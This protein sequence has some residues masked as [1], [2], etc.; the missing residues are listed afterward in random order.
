MHSKDR[1]S[2]QSSSG[3]AHSRRV[4]LLLAAIAISASLMGAALAPA[5]ASALTSPLQ[6]SFYTPPSNLASLADGTIIRSREVTMSGPQQAVTADAYQLFFRTT[7][8]TGQP[9]A[10]VT[11]VLVPKV[12]AP[13]TRVLA[14]Y[15]P[16]YDSMTLN[17]APS[18]TLQGGNPNGGGTGDL[19]EGLI[20]SELAEGWDVNVPDY[21]GL[22]SE[23]AVAPMLGHASLDS[24]IAAEHFAADGLTAG[25][26]TKV[27]FTGYS[28]GSEAADWAA[29]L[30]PSYAPQLNIIGIAAGGNFPDFDYTL[31]QFDGSLWYGIEIG[32][33]ESFSRAYQQINLKQLLNPAGQAL[34]AQDGSN[35][36]GCSS[37]TLNEPYGNASEFTNF[38]TSEAFAADPTVKQV[39]D[40]MSLRYAPYPNVPEYLYNSVDDDVA[41]IIP[42]DALVK[43]YCAAG[44]QVD[45]DRDATG[46]D[47]ITA[48]PHW[49][50]GALP[51]LIDRYAGDSVPDNCSTYGRSSPPGNTTTTTRSRCRLGAALVHGTAL[52]PARLHMTRAR[53]RHA[54]GRRGV[55][56]GA[57]IQVFCG[58]AGV[59]VGY[60]TPAEMGTIAA[61]RRRGLRGHLVWA[62]TTNSRY[63]LHDVRDG[64]S[65][66][67]PVERR[68]NLTLAAVH[69]R[70][71]WYLTRLAGATGL[72]E[73]R[74]GVVRLIG[75][76]A[77]SLTDR[78]AS[79]RVLLTTIARTARI[80]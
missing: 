60:A 62:V 27:T 65:L 77:R 25:A 3:G 75:I 80:G 74:A 39:L 5:A 20:A 49:W 50:A 61:S 37:S 63:V 10:T 42:V 79:R 40:K 36:A 67:R 22:Q 31:G 7:N 68:A 47:H 58:A 46:G 19:E 57:Y 2:D 30:A 23:W 8:A 34:A 16:A 17:C 4:A 69:G 41:H 26:K 45:Y 71:R 6:D 12:P 59:R 28:G 72:V 48:I 54:F 11:T 15:Q 33:M 66:I 51:Y 78:P 70:T 38:P 1:H 44:V 18:Y 64:Y 56:H 9:T 24:V 14:T 73:T 76:A 32:V 13:G 43:Q 53:A 52:G 21:E 55:S 29:A 35:S